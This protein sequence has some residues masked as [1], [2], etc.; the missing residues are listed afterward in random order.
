MQTSFAHTNMLIKHSAI[1]YHVEDLAELYAQLQT[2]ELTFDQFGRIIDQYLHTVT[3]FEL[4]NRMHNM[5]L[6]EGLLDTKGGDI[7]V[8]VKR[9]CVSQNGGGCLAQYNEDIKTFRDQLSFL[10]QVHGEALLLHQK[11]LLYTKGTTDAL[12]DRYRE[13]AKYIRNL[14]NYRPQVYSQY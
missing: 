14:F 1:I 13:R 6:A 10:D 12:R 9:Q 4:Q 2:N 8:T 5:I 11:W 3:G 7:F